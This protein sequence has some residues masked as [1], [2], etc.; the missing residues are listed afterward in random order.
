MPS[1]LAALN[2]RLT[3]D[4]DYDPNLHL[5]SNS[6]AAEDPSAPLAKG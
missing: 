1:F 5:L 2:R 4:T 6:A 3:S